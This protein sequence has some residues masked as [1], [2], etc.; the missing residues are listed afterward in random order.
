MG[1]FK[2]LSG[3][4]KLTTG[5]RIKKIDAR[6]TEDEYNQISELEIELGISK[7]ELVRM[8]VLYNAKQL[9]ANS[10]ELIKYLDTVGAEMGRIG[11]NINQL[12]KHANTL[13]LRG[14][15]SPAVVGKFNELLES[16]I[17]VQQ[18]LEAFLRKIIRAMGN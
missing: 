8:R 17:R 4:P 12:A 9:V 16:Y 10:K 3:R 1:D 11:N 6:F 18:G 2:K 15:L 5:K 13:N 14:D 7:T